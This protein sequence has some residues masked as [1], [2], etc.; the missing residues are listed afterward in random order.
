MRS[1]KFS[2][3]FATAETDDGAALL[4]A[5]ELAA[6]AAIVDAAA[7]KIEERGIVPD[8]SEDER[9]RRE[10]LAVLDLPYSYGTD[11]KPTMFT[12]TLTRAKDVM[13]E[14]AARIR[15]AGGHYVHLGIGGSALGSKLLVEALG[16][17]PGRA[18]GPVVDIHAPDNID[19]SVIAGILARLDPQKTF[20]NVVS[21]SGDTVESVANFSIFREFLVAAGIAGEDLAQRIF[22]TTDP[23]NGSLIKIARNER[24][25]VLPLPTAVH[26]RFSVFAPT[27][28]FTAMV[29]GVDIDGLLEGARAADALTR[30]APFAE[31]PARLLAGIHYLA[32]T[33]HGIQDLV[34]MTYSNRI[35]LVADWY[36]Q[37]VAESL[38][39]QG[40][41]ITPIKAIGATDQHS[42]LQLYN[43]GPKNKLVVL[44]GV[45]DHGPEQTM[46]E[47]ISENDGYEY[48]GGQSINRL[49]NAERLGTEISLY[50]NG[51]PSCRFD[52]ERVEPY[53][54]GAL[55]TILGKTVCILGEL[56]GVNAFD[57]PGVEESKM[58][59]RAMMGK[60]GAE[61][62][63][64][65]EMIAR[66]TT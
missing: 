33:K 42:Q 7:R 18:G 8:L 35:A 61:Y 3:R 20:V 43:D 9:R 25:T 5:G 51:V 52:L 41:G 65:R 31:N 58:Y 29:A 50:R 40:S 38:G 19:P 66:Y 53:T 10:N 37:L 4:S 60:E 27:G 22:V 57:Q 47:W 54:V 16:E 46:P 26:G 32:N 2:H 21:K 15:N 56:Y 49:L 45:D 24:Y 23:D 55:L 59:A 30:D 48:L 12:E 64:I 28:L 34:L 13:A 62:D 11:Q 63:D 17:A 44:F 36:S 14:G 39:K 6:F 1:V